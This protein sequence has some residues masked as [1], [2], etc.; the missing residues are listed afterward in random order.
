MA[1]KKSNLHIA[2]DE[3]EEK[4]VRYYMNRPVTAEL[5]VIVVACSDVVSLDFAI[6]SLFVVATNIV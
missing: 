3:K 5:V 2:I 6:V 1:N 4:S